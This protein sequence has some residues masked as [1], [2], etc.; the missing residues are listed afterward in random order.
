MLIVLFNQYDGNLLAA[1]FENGC[2]AVW[3][4]PTGEI[5]F[6]VTQHLERVMGI[7]WSPFNYGSFVTRD[8][9]SQNLGTFLVL[10]I[11]SDTFKQ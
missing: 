7:Y 2:V 3:Q 4:Y 8:R 11:P 1:G 10:S 5:V 6:K 9:V